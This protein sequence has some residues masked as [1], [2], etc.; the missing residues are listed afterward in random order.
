MLL[1]MNTI[2][3]KDGLLVESDRSWRADLLIEGETIA[4]IAPV[5]LRRVRF[6]ICV[7]PGLMVDEIFCVMRKT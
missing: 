4:R 3:I 1:D 5:N 2:L 6:I 7:S